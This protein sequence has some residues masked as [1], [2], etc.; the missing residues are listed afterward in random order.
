MTRTPRRLLFACN[1]NSVRS[2]MAEALARQLVGEDWVVESCGV[3]AGIL[4]PFVARVLEEI[5]VPVPTRDPQTFSKMDLDKWDLVVALTPE[6]AAEARRL[7]GRVE[8][9]ETANPTDIRGNDEVMM[10]AYRATRDQLSA[11]IRQAFG[12]PRAA[13]D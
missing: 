5:D 2:P 12:A 8:F 7:G 11:R 13:D 4:D 10:D 9:W 3:Y 1:M 6:A